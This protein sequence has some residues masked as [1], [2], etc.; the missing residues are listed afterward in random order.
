MYCTG[1]TLAN[2]QLR[3]KQSLVDPESIPD[4]QSREGSLIIIEAPHPGGPRPQKATLIPRHTERPG[5]RKTC[6]QPRENFH[7]MPTLAIKGHSFLSKRWVFLSAECTLL[8]DG[9]DSLASSFQ[10]VPVA[11]SCE[12]I[13]TR[14]LRRK[15]WRLVST[16]GTPRLPSDG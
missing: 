5:V 3:C 14:K 7:S 11:L 9:K 6:L 13:R 1:H 2:C 12:H 4:Y 10:K 15:L 8:N 16:I